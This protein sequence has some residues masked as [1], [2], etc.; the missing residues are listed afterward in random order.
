MQNYTFCIQTHS[1][2]DQNQTWKKLKLFCQP[3]LRIISECISSTHPIFIHFHWIPLQVFAM[4]TAFC[5]WGWQSDPLFPDTPWRW[6]QW[7]NFHLL[8]GFNY[9]LG[10]SQ[11][12][13]SLSLQTV[14]TEA[15]LQAL[16]VGECSCCKT[17]LY[18]NYKW[19]QL[20]LFWAVPKYRIY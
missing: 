1:W 4:P 15:H 7:D 3:E 20:L 17:K 8:L 10:V 2:E 14:Q 13:F 11:H 19:F 16:M 9:A 18:V 12:S 5:Q 6:K